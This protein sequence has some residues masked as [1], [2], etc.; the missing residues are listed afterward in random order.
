M[1]YDNLTVNSEGHLCFAGFD[2]AELAAIYRILAEEGF[3]IDIVSSGE[4]YTA[5]QSGFDMK[6]AF[7]HGNIKPTPI[8]PLPWK[9]G[10]VVLYAIIRRNWKRSKGKLHAGVSYSLFCFA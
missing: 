10:S 2:T 4:L 6:K 1:I 9:T 8:F 3:G 7:S 5:L